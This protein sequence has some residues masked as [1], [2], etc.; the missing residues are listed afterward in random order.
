VLASLAALFFLALGQAGSFG[1]GPLRVRVN[2]YTR[3]L[4]WGLAAGILLLVAEWRRLSWRFFGIT[5][6]S[7]LALL[8]LVNFARSAAPIITD[9]DI[10]VTELYVE[11]ATRGQLIVGPY[12]RFGWHHPGPLYFYL[13]APFYA[14]SGHQATALYAGA[15]AINL[16]SIAVLGWVVAREGR[17][18]LPIFVLG[19]CLLLAWRV[20]M[21]L[22]SPWTAH[23]SI[24]PSL[25]FLALSA[26]VASG[27]VWML[28]VAVV[29]GSFA[30][31][32]HVAFVPLVGTAAIVMAV[33]IVRHGPR[34][35]TLW[36]AINMSAWTAL[37]LWAMPLSEALSRAGGNVAAMW[38]FFVLDEA[39]GHSLSEAVRN[40][41]YGLAGVL[42]PDLYLPWGGHFGLSHLGW[43]IPLAIGSAGLLAAIAHASF[44]KGERLE[45]WLSVLALVGSLT[46]LWALTRIRGDILSHDVFRLA[47][48]GALNFAI[49]AAAGA[50][51]LAGRAGLRWNLQSKASPAVVSGVLVLL[52]AV[53]GVAHLQ[54]MT[55]LERRT[56]GRAVAV[57]AYDAIR[58]YL[59]EQRVDKPVI[60]IGPERWGAAAGILLRFAQNGTPVSVPDSNLQM[61]TDAFARTFDEGAIV[62]LADVKL[63]E[64]QRANPDTVVLVEAYPLFVDA[65]K[66]SP[67]LREGR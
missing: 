47:A 67:A 12:S 44:R 56:K 53:L 5:A 24:L 48:P 32:T 21:F 40:W 34:G 11:L 14:L 10:A 37:L 6:V 20:P 23:V 51:L 35:P 58:A 29:F 66:I 61:F 9:S 59:Q 1:V 64:E 63:H 43:A 15:L 41:S 28:P 36:P 52:A 3:P 26:S 39:S 16:V 50:S 46:G 25:T 8:G 55:S 54:A 42:R 65:L 17:H 13:L 19:A 2:D 60:R 45:G 57:V 27:R 7:T 18:L 33:G 49:I 31:Q 4:V 30:A 38:R 22:G 62:T